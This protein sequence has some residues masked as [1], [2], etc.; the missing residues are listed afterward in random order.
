MAITEVVKVEFKERRS[1]EIS[2]TLQV[3]YHS[4]YQKGHRDL[5]C[6]L[7][8]DSRGPITMT[9]KMWLWCLPCMFRGFFFNSWVEDAYDGLLTLFSQVLLTSL[10]K[11]ADFLSHMPPWRS[12]Y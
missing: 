11:E 4:R 1:R 9:M 3:S 5:E 8:K 10:V 6:V 2:G 7:H 12:G